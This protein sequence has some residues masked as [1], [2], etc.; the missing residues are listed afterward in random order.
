MEQDLTVG[1][2]QMTLVVPKD[3]DAVMDMYI[4]AGTCRQVLP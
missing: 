4:D 1:D 2:Q 3:S